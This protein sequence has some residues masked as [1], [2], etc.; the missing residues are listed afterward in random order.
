MCPG[1]VVVNSASDEGE[2]VTN[3][4]SYFARDKQN[5]NSA[6]L[7]NVLP[8]DFK[9]DHPLGGVYFQQKY[10]QQA[11]NLTKVFIALPKVWV[12]F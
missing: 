4:M 12:N 3:G 8:S 2:I 10:E 11:F 5:A 1:G 6:V 7:V 9:T